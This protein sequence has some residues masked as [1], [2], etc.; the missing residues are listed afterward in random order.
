M[1]TQGVHPASRL[2]VREVMDE[3]RRGVGGY[4]AH[5]PYGC[6]HWL[7]SVRCRVCTMAGTFKGTLDETLFESLPQ[8][9]RLVFA[10]VALFAVSQ[11]CSSVYTLFVI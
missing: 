9:K 8:T 6:V 5:K 1:L 7:P 2:Y 4:T 10:L 3:R 11:F